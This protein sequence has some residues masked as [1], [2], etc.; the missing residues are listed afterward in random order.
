MEIIKLPSALLFLLLLVSCAS[1]GS[2]RLSTEYSASDDLANKRFVLQFHNHGSKQLCLSPAT[3]P[4]VVGN[5]PLTS[6]D[7][8]VSIGQNVFPL[9]TFIEDCRDC[10]I[11]VKPHS[12]LIGY[13]DYR[14]FKIPDEL[15]GEHKELHLLPMA[16]ACD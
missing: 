1:T 3:W 7:I 9:D 12:L 15:A 11:T 2:D 4:N 10:T 13:L 16:V 14:A 5:I 8:S 6:A